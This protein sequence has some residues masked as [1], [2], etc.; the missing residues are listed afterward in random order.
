MDCLTDSL[1]MQ[2]RIVRVSQ[3]AETGP[4]DPFRVRGTQY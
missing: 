4:A 1:V 3:G 2:G